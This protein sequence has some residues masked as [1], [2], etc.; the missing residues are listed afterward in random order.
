MKLVKLILSFSFIFFVIFKINFSL[1]DKS[2]EEASKIYIN[3]VQSILNDV[4]HI[5]PLNKNNNI[6]EIFKN[7]Q[8][9][10]YAFITSNFAESTGFAATP[11]N[12]LVC[13]SVDG[14]ILGAELLSHS[15]PLFLY[16]QDVIVRGQAEGVLYKFIYQYQDKELKGLAINIKNVE[17]KNRIDGVSAATITSILMHQSIKIA[18]NKVAR[19]VSIPGFI[20]DK[21]F[22]D[23]E[24]YS[25]KT[26]RELLKDGSIR[27]GKFIK[28]EEGKVVYQKDHENKFDNEDSYLDTYFSFITKGDKG[29]IQ[30]KKDYEEKSN[31][32]EA[33]LD[34]YFAYANPV[35]IGRN[36]LGKTAYIK[37][38]LRS[39]RSPQDRGFFVSSRGNFSV[40]TPLRC[41]ENENSVSRKNCEKRGISKNHFDRIYIEQNGKKFFF[42]TYDRSNFMFTRNIEDSTP[43]FFNEIALLFIDNPEAF[44]P[45]QNWNLVI[46]F[47]SRFS[48]VSK[49]FSRA[50]LE[51]SPPKRLIVEPSL[52][53]NF[54]NNNWLSIWK[55]QIKNLSIL[56]AFI[57]ICSLIL[58]FRTRL[59]KNRKIYSTI[60]I[61]AMLFCLIWV[62]WIA[63]AQLTIVNILN[64]IQLLI[65][66]NFN[67][68]VIVF[69][70]L[71]TVVSI[72][73]FVS[74]F[75]VGRGFFCGWLCPFGALQEILNIV[76][77]SLGLKQINVKES[78]HN[79]L[80]VLKY[81]LLFLI[82][83]LM[84]YELD[85]ALIMTEIEPFKTAI[86]LKFNRTINYVIYAV[87]LLAVSLFISRFYCRYVCPLGAFLALGG[88]FRI[89]NILKRRA[90]CGSPCH[91]CEQSCPTQAI[92]SSGKIN[93]DECFYCMD[94]QEEYYDDHRC[95]PL[96]A[97]LREA[98]T[99]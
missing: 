88:K 65:T 77:Q 16:K 27:Y 48:T 87:V 67:Y 53:E 80:L 25:P 70:P 97:K 15:E 40:L 33:F 28:T 99:Y 44:D 90:E 24:T 96:V 36:I 55:M 92:K 91:L 29:R 19:F 86:T 49:F 23:H 12:I 89:F 46:N 85:L 22:I 6:Y 41:L 45:A 47:E 93:M 31:E 60:R 61:A 39:G 94:C 51:Y 78:V 84:F 73:T 98:E 8:L 50:S 66:E 3:Q 64:Y 14:V 81:I 11:F 59:V 1:A 13:M 5:S 76:A 9:I 54:S 83:V 69:D 30:Y 56:I 68:S 10:G 26:W 37:N 35:G 21:A 62:G 52:E 57:S 79:I 4:E 32:E 2:R 38:F 63:G 75:I 34:I 42:R 7:E 17:D 20:T 95:P 43:R 82:I 71:I 18:A 58:L 74:F 72:V